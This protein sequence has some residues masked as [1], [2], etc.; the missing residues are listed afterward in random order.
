MAWYLRKAV[1]IG[2]IRLNLSKGGVGAS[3]GV[4]GFRIG[5]RPDGSSYVHAGRH[6]LYIREEIGERRGGKLPVS[7][8][9]AESVPTQVFEAVSARDLAN[10][11]RK[12][13]ID[14]LNK[15]YKSFRLDYFVFAGAAITFMLAWFNA[16]QFVVVK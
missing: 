14:L 4:T 1:S 9:T 11:E 5:M 8:K 6:G 10:P 3:I 16:S 13:L 2:P 7:P 12:E 15:S